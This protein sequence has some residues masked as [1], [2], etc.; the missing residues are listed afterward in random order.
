MEAGQ[1]YL[2]VLSLVLVGLICGVGVLTFD[3]IAATR[4]AVAANETDN[5][6]QAL[7]NASGVI[8]D[9]PK[10]WLTLIVTISVLSI[11]IVMIVRSFGTFAQR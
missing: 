7:K 5:V 6:V 10:T 8:Q 1:L 3:K 4:T 11:V 2:L 9:V